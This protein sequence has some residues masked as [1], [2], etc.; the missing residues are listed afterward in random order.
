MPTSVFCHNSSLA[1]AGDG[2][3]EFGSLAIGDEVEFEYIDGE[4]GIEAVKVTAAVQ[5]SDRRR[6]TVTAF[7]DEKGYGF[8]AD[9]DPASLGNKE[10]P[11]ELSP[12]LS[13][14]GL[15]T[16]RTFNSTRT[17][18]EDQVGGSSQDSGRR[19]ARRIRLGV[20]REGLRSNRH[21]S[22]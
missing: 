16:R 22:A 12:S 13:W 3:K 14:F 4:R 9:S 21:R 15:L 20:D 10:G 1:W 19:R 7:N 2:S 18:Q 8:A 17:P 11:S 6:G 5:Y